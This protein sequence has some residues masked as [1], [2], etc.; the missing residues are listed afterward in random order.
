M[1]FK[2]IHPF[3]LAAIIGFPLLTVLLITMHTVRIEQTLMHPLPLLPIPSTNI[4]ISKSNMILRDSLVNY[5]QTLLGTPYVTAS[6]NKDGFD[7]SGFV[8]Y[9]FQHFKIIVPRSSSEFKNFGKTVRIDS[10]RIGDILVFLSP[11]KNEIGHVGII[12]IA[13]GMESEFIHA[14]SG[15]EMKV[16]ISSLK[17]E[18]Y[19]KRFVKVVDVLPHPLSPSP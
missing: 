12:T 17:Q 10:A 4:P 9:V 7:C 15:G 16:M 3:R 18:G 14:S 1:T 13:N 2:I 19:K 6:C 5:A 11:T 8:F